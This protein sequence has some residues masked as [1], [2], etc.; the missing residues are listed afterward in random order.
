M[1]SVPS[2]IDTGFDR[3]AGGLL[4]LDM[5]GVVVRANM[6]FCSW[7]GYSRAEVEGLPFDRFITM[8]GRVF[9]QTHW[10]P[11]MQMQGSVAELKLFL[12]HKD[13]RRLPVLLNAVRH[14]LD[15]RMLDEIALMV[16]AERHSYERELLAARKIA[17]QALEDVKGE[18]S[19]RTAAEERLRLLNV[20][21]IEANRFKDEFL[22]TL[23]HELRNPLAP[24][25][26][27]T[28]IL[29][30]TI[31]SDSL[32]ARISGILDRQISHMTRLVDDLSDI[33][34]ITQGKIDLRRSLVNL[35]E[36]VA[37]VVEAVRPAMTAASHTFIVQICDETVFI[38]AD[39]TR[40]LQALHNLLNNSVKYTPAGGKIWLIVECDGVQ[41]SLSVRDTGIGIANSELT[42]IFG[43]FSQLTPGLDRSQ[44]GLGIG[45]ALVRA[46]VELHSGSVTATS[47]GTGLGS[48]FI[49]RLPVKERPAT[50]Q[51]SAPALLPPAVTPRRVLIV[52]DDK[53]AAE[54]LEMILQ[55]DGHDVRICSDGES[56]LH[57]TDSFIPDMVL[58]DIEL[59]GLNG[60]EVAKRLRG[61]LWDDSVTLV[62][63]TGWGRDQDKQAAIEAGFDHHFLKP[64]DIDALTTLLTR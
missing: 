44:G 57:E 16:V 53:D 59:P 6:T 48:E 50:V 41:V 49:I 45:L 1:E 18:Q 24:M 60:Y 30:K 14:N 32:H 12:I 39:S 54:S 47:A 25:R 8:G 22:A 62:A 28:E 11:L 35:N 56:A 26:N 31:P 13:G 4:T 58:L 29:K 36:L 63:I 46:L 3:A 40:I 38:E 15:G 27:A 61:K 51:P 55:M 42:S 9:S 33:S 23:A 37:T 43:M 52:D 2:P 64:M 20:K 19:A 34:R 7:F 10:A 5:D 17:A 21:L